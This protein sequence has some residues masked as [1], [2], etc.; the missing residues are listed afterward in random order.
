MNDKLRH[1]LEQ[2][3]EKNHTIAH[4]MEEDPEFL[5]LCED[6]GICAEAL[7]YWEQ[8]KKPEAETRVNEYRTVA[9]EIEQEIREELKLRGAGIEK[10]IRL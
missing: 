2:F 5:A 6:Y 1:I 7:R 8:S 4:L 9:R 10:A 3:P